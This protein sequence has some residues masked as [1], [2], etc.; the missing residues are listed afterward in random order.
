MPNTRRNAN[1][2]LAIAIESFCDPFDNWMADIKLIVAAIE[3]G[4]SY[5][6]QVK[7]PSLEGKRWDDEYCSL[8]ARAVSCAE[9]EVIEACLKNG[10]D[11]NEVLYWVREIPGPPDEGPVEEVVRKG[12]PWSILSNRG[13][14]KEE[15][16]QKFRA[17]LQRYGAK[18]DEE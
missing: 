14:M 12:T 5:K 9:Y 1:S 3:A 13:D 17:L 6:T 16:R 15:E 7:I 2:E 8:F 4:F 11:A 18:I 10:A